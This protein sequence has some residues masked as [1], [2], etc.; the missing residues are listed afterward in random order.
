MSMGGYSKLGSRASHGC[1]RMC[2]ADAKWIY[3]NV[4]VGTSVVVTSE[5][6][7]YGP[8]PVKTKSGSKYKGWDPTDPNPD[9]PYNKTEDTTTT[10]T[11]KTTTT[12]TKTTT[13]K[14]TT[15]TSKTTTSTTTTTSK[16]TTP[17]TPEPD[18]DPVSDEPA[19]G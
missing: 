7:P 6:G 9:N 2:C 10:T 14:T 11:T 17:T 16:T 13:S 19:V 3:D 18:P 15:T 8:S 5:A 1:I 12:T 4:P